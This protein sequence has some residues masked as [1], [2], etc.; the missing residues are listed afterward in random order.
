M[1]D[2]VFRA[3]LR[4]ATYASSSGDLSFGGELFQRAAWG[5]AGMEELLFL[6][7]A[8][9]T[10]TWTRQEHEELSADEQQLGELVGL[11]YGAESAKSN[12]AA[13]EAA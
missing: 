1:P 6:A 8:K 13:S 2:P 9:H 11:V 12:K 4:E 10:P 3:A 5:P 7:L